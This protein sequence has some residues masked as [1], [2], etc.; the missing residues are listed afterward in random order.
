MPDDTMNEN[1]T[2]LN[3]D[4]LPDELQKLYKNFQSDYTK[5]MQA[6]ADERRRYDTERQQFEDK[7]KTYGAMEQEVRHWRDWY[8]NLEQQA[9]NSSQPNAPTQSDFTLD[10]DTTDMNANKDELMKQYRTLQDTV[11]A[12]EDKLSG[13]EGSLKASTDQTTRMF[14]Y[15]SQLDDLIRQHPNI[16][17][18]KLVDHALQNGFTDLGRAYD[19]L[20]RDEIINAEV[21]KRLGERLAEERTK[22]IHGTGR[23]VI[24]R[25]RSDGPKTFAEATESIVNELAAQGKLE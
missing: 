11:K 2:D 21:E 12:L 3:P 16:E 15:K 20:Y 14:A 4:E 13:V 6:I 19:D 5:K 23:Q 10:E 24:L 1:F 22:G 8:E 17:R 18:D 25:P 7:L 9:L